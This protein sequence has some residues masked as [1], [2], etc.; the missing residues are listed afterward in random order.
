MEQRRAINGIAGIRFATACQH[1]NDVRTFLEERRPLEN[2]LPLSL[3]EP[4]LDWLCANG[5][6]R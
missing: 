4:Q 2:E 1:F 3:K 6:E 5:D